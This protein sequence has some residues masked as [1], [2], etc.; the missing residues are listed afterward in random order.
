ML[1]RTKRA[2][3]YPHKISGCYFLR[4][5]KEPTESER[6][7]KL[8]RLNIQ[9]TE[10]FHCKRKKDFKHNYGTYSKSV[11][12]KVW[13]CPQCSIK[14][15]VT[16]TKHNGSLSSQSKS[17]VTA[18]IHALR[19]ISNWKYVW[20]QDTKQAW[21]FR[22]NFIT[23]TI[24]YPQMH[25]DQMI[26]KE[27]FNPM[28]K[29]LTQNAKMNSYVWKAEAQSNG[30]LHFHITTNVFIH[31]AKVRKKWNSYLAKLGYIERYFNQHGDDDPPSAEVK[32]VKNDNRLASYIAGELTKKDNNKNTCSFSC[33]V[34]NGYYTRKSY[35]WEQNSD[36]TFTEKKR[37]IEC[38]LWACSTNLIN[39]FT[40]YTNPEVGYIPEL[41][42]LKR[43]LFYKTIKHDYGF[44]AFF[45]FNAHRYLPEPFKTNM[46][47]MIKAI[48]QHE[49]VSGTKKKPIQVKSLTDVSKF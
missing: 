14:H 36:G 16:L 30:D 24:P 44:S 17:K 38:R 26:M 43:E 37:I 49:P 5:H 13:I 3:L 27:C 6:L 21:K 48:K 47:N 23:L 40:T 34:D 15:S 19:L 35:E 46:S 42:L 12:G 41:G 9:L 29:Y 31:Y 25:S 18:A 45:K 32:A 22:M 4:E 7:D 39:N 28:L 11:K 1:I 10:C 33:P 20:V 2:K 8:I